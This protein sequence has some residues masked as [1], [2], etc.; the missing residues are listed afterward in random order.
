MD[1]LRSKHVHNKAKW[2]FST[3][4]MQWNKTGKSG[5]ISVDSNQI[6]KGIK[7]FKLLNMTLVWTKN[8]QILNKNNQISKLDLEVK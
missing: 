4:G 3:K 8:R 7:G 2:K 6:R 1:Q 5:T